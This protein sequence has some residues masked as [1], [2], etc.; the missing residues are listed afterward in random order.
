MIQRNHVQFF[1]FDPIHSKTFKGFTKEQ[2]KNPYTC[3][4]CIS[5]L[6]EN[7]L[8]WKACV[9]TRWLRFHCFKKKH[10]YTLLANVPITGQIYTHGK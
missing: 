6:V 9:D 7:L 2:P 4:E 5:S 1:N 8:R 3:T 10:R